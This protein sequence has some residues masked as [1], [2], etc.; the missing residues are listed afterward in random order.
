MNHLRG[1]KVAL[2][3]LSLAALACALTNVLPGGGDGG[4]GGGILAGPQAEPLTQTYTNEAAGFSM[5]LPEGWVTEDLFFMTIA[6]ETQEAL[7]SDV[8]TVP[9]MIALAGSTEVVEVVPEETIE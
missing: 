7:E 4:D 1:W 9:A 8:L 6:A 5:Q 3:M 2:A